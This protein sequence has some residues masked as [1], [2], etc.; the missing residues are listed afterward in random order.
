MKSRRWRDG[1]WVVY[2][3]LAPLIPMMKTLGRGVTLMILLLSAGVVHA[4]FC[5]IDNFGNTRSCFPSADMCRQWASV[6]PGGSC[7]LRGTGNSD[8]ASSGS[9]GNDSFQKFGNMV[10]QRN[11]E[12]ERGRDAT[13]G[14]LIPLTPSS[15]YLTQGMVNQITSMLNNM[16]EMAEGEHAQPWSSSSGNVKGAMGVEPI[17]KNQFGDPCRA[18]VVTL[19]YRS[20]H[21][22]VK[23][24]A[25]RKGGNWQILGA[26]SL[27]IKDGQIVEEPKLAP[28]PLK[29]LVGS[30]CNG[31]FEC[32]NSMLC[33]DS[34]CTTNTTKVP[35]G[36]KCDLTEQCTAPAHCLY[37]T[38]IER[39]E[40]NITTVAINANCQNV[41]GVTERGK[42]PT[43]PNVSM[44]E[45]KC[46]NG[47]YHVGCTG[48]RCFYYGKELKG[49]VSIN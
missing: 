4:E 39:T 11:S 7:V 28:P 46:G 45:V 6:I 3:S 24:N 18:F 17:K 31:H 14:W 12:T 27:E 8:S 13:P 26:S 34:V 36:G 41:L 21:K 29:K 43:D 42:S 38:C 15:N 25:C 9:S 5:A 40:M 20:E 16:L 49:P 23:G 10:R 19:A 2:W 35:N 30:R 22:A 33:M 47:N 32:A 1:G 37:G 48:P 44:F